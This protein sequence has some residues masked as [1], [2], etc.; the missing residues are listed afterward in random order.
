[1]SGESQSTQPQSHFGRQEMAVFLQENRSQW[2]YRLT[3]FVDSLDVHTDARIDL[4]FMIRRWF[5]IFIDMKVSSYVGPDYSEASRPLSEDKICEIHSHFED[6]LNI[7]GM[8]EEEFGVSL[9]RRDNLR[10]SLTNA[11]DEY[12]EILVQYERDGINV[13]ED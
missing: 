8:V 7:V 11:E 3:E 10:M 9:E 12:D 6:F 5:D 1:M 13:V 2:K 4:R